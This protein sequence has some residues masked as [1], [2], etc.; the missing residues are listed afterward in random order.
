MALNEAVAKIIVAVEGPKVAVVFARVAVKARQDLA[1]L[2]TMPV[3][4]MYRP[5]EPP[6]IVLLPANTMVV[7]YF[8]LIIAFLQD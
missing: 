7:H 5:W 3:F 2:Q 8:N 1:T 4:I 6:R